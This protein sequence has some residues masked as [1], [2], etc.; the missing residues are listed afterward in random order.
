VTR[1]S[2][3]QFSILDTFG[4]GLCCSHGSGSYKVYMDNDLQISGGEF[5]E[6]EAFFFGDC[7]GGPG[8]P[9]PTP[10]LEN[11]PSPTT[12]SPTTS[13]PTTSPPTPL[14]TTSPTLTGTN[15][16]VYDPA[17]G[18]PKCGSVHSSGKC[19]TLGTKMLN[20][21]M[22]SVE[23]NPPNSL[24]ACSDGPGG[25]YGLD[26]VTGE[27]NGN[28]DESIEAITVSAADG[29]VL[30]AGGLARITA[31]VYSWGNGNTD[32]AD[33]YYAVDPQNPVW[34][35]IST[36]K[37]GSGGITDI[38]SVTFVLPSSGLQAVRVNFRFYGQ[39]SSCS[40][41]SYDDVD[42]LVFA[43]ETTSPEALALSLPAGPPKAKPSVENDVE[44]QRVDCPELP[45]DR[46]KA[47]LDVCA[48]RKQKSSG[49]IFDNS[50][51]ERVWGI[52][53]M[54]GCFP[55]K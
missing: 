17:L 50:S 4:D 20:G 47:A 44:E 34:E 18:A 10:N 8:T 12:S 46:C 42:D 28:G 45:L 25:S 26:P 43:V 5:G 32:R 21:K 52:Q 30:T 7:G 36:R 55:L 38:E 3:F 53:K 49:N 22:N 51:S 6:S 27:D 14:V 35:H 41:G 54:E 39:R 40:G 31:R 48:W 11:I 23:Q 9:K 1:S 37:A 24:D 13:P 2:R 16:A 19:T 33:F 15:L 29:G